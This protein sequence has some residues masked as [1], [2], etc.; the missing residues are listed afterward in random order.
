MGA[1]PVLT[2]QRWL[3]PEWLYTP[4]GLWQGKALH[5]NALGQVLA[6][7]EA[8]EIPAD[9][10]P[11]R[12]PGILTPGL[13]NAHCH[14]E[15][16]ALEGKILPG[17]GMAAFAGAVTS[18]RR[19]F[20][21]EDTAA[22]VQHAMDGL[23]ASGTVLV[24]DIAN[25]GIS[26]SVK[27]DHPLATYTFFETFGLMEERANALLQKCETLENEAIGV[28]L[29]AGV[30]LHAPYS[31]LPQV[32]AQVYARAR[33]RGSRIS[34]HMLESAAEREVFAH[35]TGHFA[36]FYQHI[37]VPMPDFG[38]D[39]PL[40]YLLRDSDPG[41]PILLVHT[42]EMQPAETEAFFAEYAQGYI[43]LCPRSNQWIHGTSPALAQY[44]P[45]AD[46]ICLG[47]DSLASNDSLDVA[48][49]VFACL[50]LTQEQGIAVNESLIHLLLKWATTNGAR[51]LGMEDRFGQFAP[52]T[53]PGLLAWPWDG[54]TLGKPEVIAS[55]H[56]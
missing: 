15:L 53:T 37:G 25:E 44:L 51:A 7:V 3:V 21:P 50:Q 41:Q 49:E 31:V 14:L 23:C 29:T 13:V 48:N 26:I 45:F 8:P 33:E 56:H 42:T 18:L 12:I 19:T 34:L 46:R 20:S 4:E 2:G 9:A 54:Q 36:A 11:E 38:T 47:T 43:C 39:S 55:W 1:G 17:T 52:G 6:V 10:Q 16:S 32:R 35:G 40:T 5:V 30:T 28:G 24:G 27:K 22:A